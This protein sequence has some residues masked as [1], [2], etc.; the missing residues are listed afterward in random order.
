MGMEDRLAAFLDAVFVDGPNRADEE[1]RIL[2]RRQRE[3]SHAKR[4][5]GL[6]P[7]DNNALAAAVV[8]A[9]SHAMSQNGDTDRSRSPN[10][11][12]NS[13]RSPSSRRPPKVLSHRQNSFRLSQRGS[14]RG[15]Q[16]NSNRLPSFRNERSSFGS[17]L[18]RRSQA[19]S[20]RSSERE[21]S[22]QRESSKRE[23]SKRRGIFGL[24]RRRAIVAADDGPADEEA[25]D[26][27]FVGMPAQVDGST[28][29]PEHNGAVGTILS[30]DL[31]TGTCLV[32]L[33]LPAL[34]RPSSDVGL[35]LHVKP[36]RLRVRTVDESIAGRS[37]V[38]RA[39]VAALEASEEAEKALGQTLLSDT[40]KLLLTNTPFSKSRKTA[41][42]LES[43]ALMELLE[44]FHDPAPL[45]EAT[46]D[47]PPK[48]LPWEKME[49]STNWLEVRKARARGRVS[50]RADRERDRAGRAAAGGALEA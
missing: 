6:E 24:G 42:L 17:P 36:R 50:V 18:S 19:S 39:H 28:D 22:S 8:M 25:K 30:Y 20:A 3:A 16:R 11:S 9:R 5:T 21:G 43:G 14:Q 34:G 49:P 10:S 45:S 15:S 46:G 48:H 41:K 47:A 27:N 4:R 40:V 35:Q 33:S 1:R 23:N 26:A 31:L 12:R 13:G 38:Q 44:E 37:R 29:R 32:E 7:I 2:M